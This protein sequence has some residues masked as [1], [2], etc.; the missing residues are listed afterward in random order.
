M[1]SFRNVP[2]LCMDA[3]SLGDVEPWQGV[4]SGGAV[5][6]GSSRGAV[7][8]T[9]AEQ[10]ATCSPLGGG[11]EENCDSSRKALGN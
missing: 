6:Q 11:N 2:A 7:R 1:A 8:D 10:H 4:Q 9:G 5:A 3:T